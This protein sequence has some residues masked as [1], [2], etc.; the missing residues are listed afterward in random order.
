[1]E[2]SVNIH[3]NEYKTYSSFEASY[4]TSVIGIL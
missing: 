4:G 3:T 2:T 1:M